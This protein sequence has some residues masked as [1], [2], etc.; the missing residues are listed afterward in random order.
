MT[1]DHRDHHPGR[2]KRPFH[3]RSRSTGPHTPSRADRGG[4]PTSKWLGFWQKPANRLLAFVGAVLVAVA[5]ALGT[6][7]AKQALG[8]GRTSAD[9]QVVSVIVSPGGVQANGKIRPSKIDIKLLNDGTQL[10]IIK[11]ATLVAQQ[12]VR[13]P[14]CLSQGGF[15]V[16]GTYGLTMPPSPSRGRT[17]SI[18]VS[19]LVPANGAD[20]FDIAIQA[21]PG[22]GQ[23]IFLYRLHVYLYYNNVQAPI[24]VGEVLAAVPF[25]P[26][27]GYFWIRAND[28]AK[29]KKAL[30]N[31]LGPVQ[32][33]TAERCLI[34]GSK[35]LRFVL[36]M[37]AHEPPQLAN[38]VSR[39][40][41][42]CVASISAQPPKPSLTQVRYVQLFTANGKLRASYKPAVTLKGGSCT[43]SIESSDP[44]ALRCFSGSQVADPCWRPGNATSSTYVACLKSPWDTRPLVIV[45]PRINAAPTA[46][47]GRVPWALEII[48][49]GRPGQVLQCAF[50]TGGTAPVIAGDR[51]NWVCFRPGLVNPSGL[52][53]YVIGAAHPAT[54]SP[55]TVSYLPPNSTQPVQTTVATVWR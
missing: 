25:V 16:T 9:I 20:H 47:R 51:V 42:C 13:L 38:V 49:P 53:G 40:S 46:S 27:P 12:S 24:D 35:A 14:L 10:A 34:N 26:E 29:A 3:Q 33:A 31:F 30:A 1:R 6:F 45:H 11:R 19:Q 44:N 15:P 22:K 8:T 48:Q 39:L 50:A 18:P 52:D 37:P 43:G 23:T 54:S 7:Y 17:L 4:P 55:W 41:F 36:S 28:T 32:A 2:A 21:P 5:G